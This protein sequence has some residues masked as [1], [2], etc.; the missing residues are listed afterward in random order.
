MQLVV[1]DT[2]H[3]LAVDFLRR[4]AAVVAHHL[5]DFLGA[6][7][8]LADHADEAFLVEAVLAVDVHQHVEKGLALFACPCGYFGNHRAGGHGVL[9]AHEVADH[10]AV[11]LLAAGDELFNTFEFF[12]FGSDEF[13]AGKHVVDFNSCTNGDIG[14]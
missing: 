7:L 11:A 1:L 8:A 5:L 6:A 4:V 2:H 10:V 13:E 9:V 14:G 3:F 12:D